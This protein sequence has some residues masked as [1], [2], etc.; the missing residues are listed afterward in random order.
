MTGAALCG[1]SIRQAIVERADTLQV[2]ARVE[3]AM[4]VTGLTVF[5]K[6]LIAELRC[7]STSQGRGERVRLTSRETEQCDD[8]ADKPMRVQCRP[9]RMR[10]RK[11]E[12]ETGF[13]PATF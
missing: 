13:E 2:L 7:R 10:P 6:D 3:S 4:N 1:G 12:R 5:S 11:E 8:K 9:R